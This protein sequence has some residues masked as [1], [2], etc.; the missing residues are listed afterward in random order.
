MLIAFV[1]GLVVQ[2]FAGVYT[3]VQLKDMTPQVKQVVLQALRTES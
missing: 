1:D 2:Y 3:V